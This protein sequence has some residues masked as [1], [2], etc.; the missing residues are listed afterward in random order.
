MTS[1]RPFPV[2]S[3]VRQ[4]LIV[5]AGGEASM[6]SWCRFMSQPFGYIGIVIAGLTPA[7]SGHNLKLRPTMEP[8]A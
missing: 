8:S 1:G 2:R 4:K 3:V 7:D 6:R 5:L